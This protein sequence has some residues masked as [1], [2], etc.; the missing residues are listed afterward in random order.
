MGPGALM[1]T[2]I[3]ILIL[4]LTVTAAIGVFAT[5][6][7]IPPA[8][9][10]VISGVILALAPGLPAVELAP[11]LVLLLV[12]PPIIYWSA[13]SMSWREFR[14]N[15]RLIVLLAVGC[16][17]FTTVAVAATSHWLLNFTWSVRVFTRRDRVT[18]GRC[19]AALHCSTDATS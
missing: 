2:T 1:I 12:L 16:V 4:L 13:V 8:I 19:C 6:L 10:L 7:K 5:R 11:E 15:L 18:S 14:F 3:Q 17:A 9:L